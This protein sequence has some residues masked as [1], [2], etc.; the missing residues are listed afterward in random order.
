M[1]N[2]RVEVSAVNINLNTEQIL[3]PVMTITTTTPTGIT[4]NVTW[5]PTEIQIINDC[6]AGIEWLKIDDADELAEFNLSATNHDFIRLPA[7]STLVNDVLRFGKAYKFMVKGYANTA[8]L[9][10]VVEFM[11]YVRRPTL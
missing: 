9:P 7:S 4:E 8:T 5:Y 10:L 2:K 11:S 1:K 6:G 3:D